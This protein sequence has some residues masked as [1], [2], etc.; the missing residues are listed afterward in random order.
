MNALNSI[1]LE[2]RL[3]ADPVLTITNNEAA[4]CN[5]SIAINYYY[6]KD[7]IKVE[8]VSYFDIVAWNGLA[9]SC[10]KYLSK[11]RGVRV[12]GRLKQNR[13]VDQEGANHQ[14]VRIVAEHVEFKPL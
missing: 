8:E 12:V 5:F 10:T 3:T 11:G 14:K 4:V 2:G 7:E 6:K 9:Q 1:L 13:W